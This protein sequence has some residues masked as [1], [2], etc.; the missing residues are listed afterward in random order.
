MQFIAK[1]IIDK[2]AS[3]GIVGM[4][5]AMFPNTRKASGD[6]SRVLIIND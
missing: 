1:E 6:K 5:G 2:I 4:G 3:A